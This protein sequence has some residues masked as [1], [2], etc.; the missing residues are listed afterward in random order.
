M[1]LKVH[2]Q[3]YRSITITGH[4]QGGGGGGG[5][6]GGVQLSSGKVFKDLSI[7]YFG[8]Q[9][10]YPLHRDLSTFQMTEAFPAIY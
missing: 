4:V 10:C 8:K 2:F 6:V 1:P 5:G 3:K 7:Q 9:L